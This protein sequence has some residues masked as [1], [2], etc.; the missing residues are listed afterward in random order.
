MTH[1]TTTLTLAED[2][3][4]HVLTNDRRTPCRT[5]PIWMPWTGGSRVNTTTEEANF[6]VRLSDRAGGTV[7][8]YRRPDIT[9]LLNAL[10]CGL[11]V[12]DLFERAPGLVAEQLFGAYIAL[13]QLRYRAET[14]WEMISDQGT[15]EAVVT[16]GPEAAKLVPSLVGQLFAVVESAPHRVPALV[17]AMRDDILSTRQ[18]VRT[19]EHAL[20]ESLG[21]PE[22]SMDL[23]RLLYDPSGH[24]AA[25]DPSFLSRRVGTLVPTCVAAL[26]GE[27]VDV[28]TSSMD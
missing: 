18:S 9:A 3:L 28:T 16:L 11:T 4:T 8:D 15:P 12:D 26:L 10:R 2:R 7:S 27:R 22:R 24:G 17:A 19:I 1:H 6:L 23:G 25:S 14:A 21:N 20:Q 13:E 5:P